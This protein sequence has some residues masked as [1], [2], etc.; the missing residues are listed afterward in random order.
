MNDNKK[1]MR[2]LKLQVSISVDGCI[3]GPK[4]KWTG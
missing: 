2:K 4:M 3:A 1:V